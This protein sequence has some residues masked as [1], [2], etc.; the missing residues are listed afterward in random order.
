MYFKNKKYF[1]YW[2]LFLLI[3]RVYFVQILIISDQSNKEYITM[4]SSFKMTDP[5]TLNVGILGY[6][7]ILKTPFLKLLKNHISFY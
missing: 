6:T 7:G 1:N 5:K 2:F 3:F 4:A